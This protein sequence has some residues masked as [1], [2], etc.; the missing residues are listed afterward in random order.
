V[1]VTLANGL[2]VYG[3]HQGVAA[4]PV[5]VG[6]PVA[7]H[8][9][10][11]DLVEA[12]ASGEPPPLEGVEPPPPPTPEQLADRLTWLKEDAKRRIDAAAER[13]RLQFVTSG[14]GQ[15]M[16]YIATENEANAV[17]ALPLDA[18]IM[19]GD[20]PMLD[21]ELGLLGSDVRAIA[22]IVAGE[23]TAWRHVGAHI[24]QLRRHA[25]AAVDAAATEA[26]VQAAI[27]VPWPR[28]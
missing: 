13:C 1:T 26:E 6:D 22:A 17:L 16:E 24:K 19:P 10:A 12:L 11:H 28:P 9:A 27:A 3:W 25:K 21:A 14:T 20:Y 8:Q 2:Q 23:A 18:E 7:T 15:A 5:A 4:D